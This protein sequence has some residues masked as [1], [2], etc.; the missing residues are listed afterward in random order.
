MYVGNSKGVLEFDGVYWRL[1]LLPNK[2]AARS[3]ALF[4]DNTIYVGG[5]G[6]LGYL[7]SDSTGTLIY[8]SLLPLLPETAQEFG[9][10]WEALVVGQHIFFRTS[11]RLFRYTPHQSPGQGEF[12]TWQPQE[13]FHVAFQAHNTLYVRDVG[14]G[15]FSVVEDSLTLLPNSQR[16]ANESLY[17]ALPISA[18]AS[19][20]VTRT[21]GLLL[22][23][24][25]TFSIVE[26]DISELLKQ[27][28]S[29]HAAVVSDSLIAFSTANDGLFFSTLQ[30]EIIYHVDTASGLRDNTIWY[31]YQDRE[32]GVWCALNDGIARIEFPGPLTYFQEANGFSGSAQ[33]LL[34]HQNR[35]YVAAS[36]AGSFSLGSRM[37]THGL[38]QAFFYPV[39]GI[40]TQSWELAAV[41]TQLLVATNTGIYSISQERAQPLLP[42]ESLESSFLLPSRFY[43]DRLFVGLFDGAAVLKNAN[44]TW[45]IETVIEGIGSEV[46]SMVEENAQTLWCG[47]RSNGVYRVHLDDVDG[48]Q[49]ERV[50]HFSTEHGLPSGQIFVF[51]I[52]NKVVITTES[53]GIFSFEESETYF[54]PD[55]SFGAQFADGSIDVEI[56][57][58]SPESDRLWFG[59]EEAGSISQLKRQSDGVYEI[60]ATSLARLPKTAIRALY[61]DQNDIL[62]AST[63]DGLFRYD[64]A[65]DKQ[66]NL[67]Y[68]AFIRRIML[69]PDSL[70]FG[71]TAHGDASPL[72]TFPHPLNSLRF[73]FSAPSYDAAGSLQFQTYLHGFDEQWSFWTNE[74][75]K[76]F[77]N[78][79]PGMYTFQVRAKNAYDLLSEPATFSFRVL[80]PW[81]RTLWAYGLYA[82]V[83]GGLLFAVDRVQRRRLTN[84]A[85]ERMRVALLE[86]EHRRK[87][88]ELEKA[89]QLQISMLPRHITTPEDVEIAVYMKPATEVGG[90]YYDFLLNN[91]EFTGAIG[92]A[93]GHGL[94]AGMMVSIIKGFFVSEAAHMPILDFFKKCNTALKQM[95]LQRIYMALTLFKLDDKTLRVSSAGMP[96]IYV[97]RAFEKRLE[98]VSLSG[99]PLGAVW[100]F[101]YQCREILLDTGDTVFLMSDGF[102]ELFNANQEILGY[103]RVPDIFASIAQK[104]PQDI[105]YDLVDYIKQWAQDH[106]NEDDITFVVLKI[107]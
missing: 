16:F 69:S 90:D 34:R 55:S 102:P 104:A 87:S 7:A 73:E 22:F 32:Q 71:G 54:Y 70:I 40:S 26:N 1:I 65:L 85:Q 78:L 3:L 9:D 94:N 36:P 105:V 91:N 6:E 93:T 25:T 19:W 24:G 37:T 97:Y 27:R 18:S 101:E 41:D 10:V 12:Y 14:T 21:Q 44:N 42:S 96:P 13:R 61:P 52:E 33:D 67:P 62:W 23:D 31:V 5:K 53:Q 4:H 49:I 100:D 50:Q 59:A 47:T 63:N 35:L 39:E 2:A 48:F 75:W 83:L 20:L 17:T 74:S 28:R 88:E 57:A 8:N 98:E 46:R 43:P 38:S 79:S 60:E 45:S 64:P 92:D 66:L 86:A 81:Y 99:M 76:E 80:P 30:G 103:D 82:L 84:K 68:P 29:V 11:E 51:L 77:T 89:R 106:P 58:A 72:S 56:I 107:K 95:K 15:L